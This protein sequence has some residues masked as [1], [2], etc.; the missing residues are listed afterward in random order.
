MEKSRVIAAVAANQIA[1]APAK[2]KKGK[3]DD[4][5]PAWAGENNLWSVWI[6][7]G[8]YDVNCLVRANSLGDAKNKMKP[9]LDEIR[10][11]EG[12][13]QLKIK[14]GYKVDAE[15]LMEMEITAQNI[16][17]ISKKGY[18]VYDSGS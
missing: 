4:V 10:R 3:S 8:R 16:Q 17:E 14:S 11:Q 12:A 13:D 1:A 2:Q 7:D 6:T 15:F 9:H 18:H 5:W